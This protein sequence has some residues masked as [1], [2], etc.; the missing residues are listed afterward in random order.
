MAK[1]IGTPLANIPWQDRPANSTAPVWRYSNNPI[2]QRDAIP[3]A[4]SSFNSAPVP[5]NG[6]FAGVF[7]V[8]DCSRRMTLHAGFSDDGINWQIEHDLLNL[9][10]TP[11]DMGEFDWG[12]DP[13][14]CQIDDCYLVTWCNSL[15][16]YPT[17]GM[18]ETKDF[19]DG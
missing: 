5:F 4:N 6:K 18:A 13:R 8:D 19:S 16:G 7:R 17:I 11:E 14:V 12:Y 3:N 2:I 9:T 10:E 15:A 1:I